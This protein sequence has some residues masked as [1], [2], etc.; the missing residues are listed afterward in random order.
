VTPLLLIVVLYFALGESFGETTDEKLRI[1]IVNLDNGLPAGTTFPDKSWAEVVID[2]LSAP[3]ERP[4]AADQPKRQDV[5]LEFISDLAEGEQ[6]VARGRR[7][8]VVVFGPKF[9]E[10]L[11]RCSFLTQPGSVNPL[12]RDGIAFERLDV[13]I[14]TDPAQPVSASVIKQVMQ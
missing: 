1:S 12:G 9:S 7:P 3:D 6:L 10:Q 14:L 8:A 2:D 4:G 11:D 5:R 13:R